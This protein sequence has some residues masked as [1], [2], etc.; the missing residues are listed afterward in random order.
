MKLIITVITNGLAS[1]HALPQTNSKQ[2]ELD[3]E[4]QFLELK[5]YINNLRVKEN[6]EFWKSLVAEKNYTKSLSNFERFP[7]VPYLFL[8]KLSSTL[9]SLPHSKFFGV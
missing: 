8:P 4:A 7:P 5:L 3:D 1:I 2:A 9:Q 6:L